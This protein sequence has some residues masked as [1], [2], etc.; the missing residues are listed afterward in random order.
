MADIE[1]IKKK[2]YETVKTS[3]KKLKSGDIQKKV[4][5]DLGCDRKE[6]KEAIKELVDAGELVY[7]YFG[8]SFVE[9]PPEKQG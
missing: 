2:V 5:K 7:T 9:I 1:E 8:G 6:V 4:S 3:K